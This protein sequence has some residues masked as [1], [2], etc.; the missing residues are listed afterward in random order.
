MRRKS[1]KQEINMKKRVQRCTV[2]GEKERVCRVIEHSIRSDREK[3]K[4]V[5]VKTK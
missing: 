4:K 1:A 5:T 2:T 3:R